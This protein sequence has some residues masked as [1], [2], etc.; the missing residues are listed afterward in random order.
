MATWVSLDSAENVAAQSGGVG[1]SVSVV[2]QAGNALT[3]FVMYRNQLG[4]SESISDGVNT[5]NAVGSRTSGGILIQKFVATG[6][7]AGTRNVTFVTTDGNDV[8]GIAVAQTNGS[9][10][11]DG[12]NQNTQAAPTTAANAVISNSVSS[13]GAGIAIALSVD[14]GAGVAAPA[15]GTTGSPTD[16]GIVWSSATIPARVESLGY[17]S[18][19]IQLTFTALNNNEHSTGIVLLLDGSSGITYTKTAEDS[20]VVADALPDALKFPRDVD[21]LKPT[22]YRRKDFVN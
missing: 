6:I 3:V 2:M 21:C 13:T 4:L 19:S 10:S 8:R 9:A 12:G 11:S 1:L 7:A 22:I 16:R 17:A 5:Y 15:A 18:G 20:L 14:T